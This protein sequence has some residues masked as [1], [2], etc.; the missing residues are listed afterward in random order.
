[1][2][3]DRFKILCVIKHEHK[4]ASQL[5]EEIVAW[6]LEH[7]VDTILISSHAS[8]EEFTI[9]SNGC[10]AA[11]ILGGD[12]TTLAVA[13]A[14]H[15]RKIPMIGINYGK[16][17]F[18]TEINPEDWK[19]FLPRILS[20]LEKLY[21][22]KPL[23]ENSL[24]ISEQNLLKCSVIRQNKCIYTGYAMNDAVITRVNIA[25]AISLSLSIDSTHMSDLRCDGLIVS[26]PIGA[27][28]YAI[29]AHG[30]LAMPNL[31][32]LIIT[33]ICP[34][35]GSFSPCVVDG[36]ANIEIIVSDANTATMLTLDGQENF[37]LEYN[38][39]IHITSYEHAVP[40]LVSEKGWFINRLNS[41][42]YIHK[43]PTSRG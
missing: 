31:N 10:H 17:G 36:A 38:D 6:L 5:A 20:T 22:N 41:R 34:F 14:L 25:R 11:L 33:P 15:D 12:G 1:M 3:V 18:L 39:T 2:K 27:T 35:A 9:S 30:P 24:F 29:A 28:A 26:T 19:F 42:G 23:D 4:E 32:A 13:R 16:V 40:L 21:N 8:K 7:N 43:G 37:N